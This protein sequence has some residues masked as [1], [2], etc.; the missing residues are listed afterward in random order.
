MN[1]TT[2]NFTNLDTRK[3][4]SQEQIF[5]FQMAYSYLQSG[6][7]IGNQLI[8]SKKSTMKVINN[9]FSKNRIGIGI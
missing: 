8:N 6:V 5:C 2:F 7:H 9:N 1:T 3:P 4:L